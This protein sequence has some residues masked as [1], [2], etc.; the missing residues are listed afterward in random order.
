MPTVPS[1]GAAVQRQSD[2][3]LASLLPSGATSWD[4][5]PVCCGTNDRLRILD[6]PTRG[7]KFPTVFS[8]YGP[9]QWP[10]PKSVLPPSFRIITTASIVSATAPSRTT[11]MNATPP[12]P[13]TGDNTPDIP[14]AT[15]LT[16]AA[17]TNSNVDSIPTCPELD[18]SFMSR[19]GLV[20]RLQIHRTET[21]QPIPGA[22]IYTSRTHFRCPQCPCALSHC[23]DLF[24]HVH[25]CDS[26][27]HRNIGTAS[28][29]FTS[30]NS[31]TTST[32][33][34]PSSNVTSTSSV[35]T[36]TSSAS[37]N[38]FYPYCYHTWSSH[39]ALVG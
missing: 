17:L 12:T 5:C 8:A 1:S 39:I 23:N 9:R 31:S 37:P 38:L 15:I 11:E 34:S 32:T 35:N 14:P 28:P 4:D 10:Y 30:E 29:S 18:R 7:T 33:I 6:L 2:E 13:T 16:A 21:G 25:I 27:I 36:A 24:G 26:G 20:G 3:P 19:I 22:S